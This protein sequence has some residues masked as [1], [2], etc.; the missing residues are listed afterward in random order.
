MLRACC[1]RL[2]PLLVLI[3]TFPHAVKTESQN[4]RSLTDANFDQSTAEGAW[5][6]EFFAPW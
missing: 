6:I 4:V 3:G 5:L 1:T 2:L